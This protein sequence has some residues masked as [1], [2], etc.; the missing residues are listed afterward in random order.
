MEKYIQLALDCGFSHAGALD[1]S[2]IVLKEEV[3]AMCEMNTCGMYNK[4]WA[5]P[6]A[7]GDLAECTARIRKYTKGIIVQTTQE[8]EDS[9]DYE[10]I[11]ELGEKHKANFNKTLDRLVEEFPDLLPLGTGGCKQ[12]ANCT[13]PDEPC[14]FPQKRI[15]SM[16]AYGM[17]VNEVCVANDIPYYYGQNT[18]TYIACF[19]LK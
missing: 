3:R 8:L 1:P 10:G 15:S 16:E 2:K 12:C 9:M 7:C 6:P 5:C 19:L 4:S 14:R 17:V 13:Y 11:M 18:L